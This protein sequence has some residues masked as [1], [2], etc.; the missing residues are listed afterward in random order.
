[1]DVHRKNLTHSIRCVFDIKSQQT[2]IT[3][4]CM[5]HRRLGASMNTIE[6]L[7]CQALHF[8]KL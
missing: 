5:K 4:Q 1:M 6:G 3:R 2:H 8:P 7:N